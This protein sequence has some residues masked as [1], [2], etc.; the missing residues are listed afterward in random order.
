[1]SSCLHAPVDMKRNRQ[2]EVG[3]L[4]TISGLIFL[5]FSSVRSWQRFGLFTV[6]HLCVDHFVSLSLDFTVRDIMSFTF[7]GT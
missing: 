6:T 5:S 1:M 4:S 2:V 3:Q 7:S